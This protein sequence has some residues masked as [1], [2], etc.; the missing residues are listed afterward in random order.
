MSHQLLVSL[1]SP[2]LRSEIRDAGEA[3]V[4]LCVLS[5]HLALH[6]S[7][8]ERFRW[9]RRF[10]HSISSKDLLYGSDVKVN[11]AIVAWQTMHS[12]VWPRNP[13]SEMGKQ[14]NLFQQAQFPTKTINLCFSI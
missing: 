5:S 7:V 4:T 3:V 10:K 11:Q 8:V 13:I 2:V 9:F 6:C 1:H 14:I 12:A